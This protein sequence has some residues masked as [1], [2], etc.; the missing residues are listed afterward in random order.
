MGLGLVGDRGQTASVVANRQNGERVYLDAA[1]M[2]RAA[3]AAPEVIKDDGT[4][5]NVRFT[6]ER[7]A[8]QYLRAHNRKHPDRPMKFTAARRERPFIEE[9]VDLPGTMGGV[10][11]LRSCV[12]STL[13]LVAEAGLPEAGLEAAWAFV[14]GT[15][16]ASGEINWSVSPSPWNSDALGPFRHLI[17]V[18]SDRPSRS[19]RMHVR[20][21][22]DA[23]MVGT[24]AKN[25]DCSDWKIAYAVDPITGAEERT[26]E[27][28]GDLGSSVD[29]ATLGQFWGT[30]ERLMT[31]TMQLVDERAAQQSIEIMRQRVVHKHVSRLTRERATKELVEEIARDIAEEVTRIHFRLDMSEDDPELVDRLNSS[32]RGEF[33]A[34]KKKPP[35]GNS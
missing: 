33:P 16:E 25:V 14:A 24:L 17:A 23:A 9:P 10:E 29:E 3:P 35:E 15:A 28:V 6:S 31:R 7:A 11:F 13:V 32:E 18:V 34:E 19:I 26:S 21:F 5:R 4:T 20:Y 22:G 2:P 12:K 27:F 30:F 1:F 8:R